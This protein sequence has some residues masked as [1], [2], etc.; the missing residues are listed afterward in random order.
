M[1]Q[2]YL[3]RASAYHQEMDFSVIIDAHDIYEAK[4]LLGSTL[5][6]AGFSQIRVT[7]IESI[8]VS[9]IQNVPLTK[10]SL[11]LR[12]ISKGE[13]IRQP[14]AKS[15]QVGDKFYWEA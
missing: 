11:L 2:H 12:A 15:H 10:G 9:N 5:V 1:E 14:D 4:W 13:P 7:E 8:P 3:Y 6:A